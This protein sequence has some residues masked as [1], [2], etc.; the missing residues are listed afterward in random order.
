MYIIIVIKHLHNQHITNKNN[1][2]IIA[3]KATY[4]QIY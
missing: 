3:I 1:K 2:D 4:K